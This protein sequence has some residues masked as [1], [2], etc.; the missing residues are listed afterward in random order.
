MRQAANRSAT[1]RPQRYHRLRNWYFRSDLRW[2]NKIRNGSAGLTATKRSVKMDK[3]NGDRAER[4][5]FYECEG[6][7]ETEKEA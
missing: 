1:D 4:I 3:R 2:P 5:D 6:R 7:P